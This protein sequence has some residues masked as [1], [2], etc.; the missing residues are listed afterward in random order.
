MA[1]C[2]FSLPISLVMIGRIYTLSDYHHQIGSMNDYSL[3]RVR[4]WNNDMRCMF[5]YIFICV[6]SNMIPQ[7][8]AGHKQYLTLRKT[9][10]QA[11]WRMC[12]LR[13]NTAGQIAT[14]YNDWQRKEFRPWTQSDV[15]CLTHAFIYF[16]LYRLWNFKAISISSVMVLVTA[17]YL[18]TIPGLLIS[19]ENACVVA[20]MQKNCSL[21]P[22]AT[23]KYISYYFYFM[24]VMM[25]W[26]SLLHRTLPVSKVDKLGAIWYG[27]TA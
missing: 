25:M 2:V 7:D 27:D 16:K 11:G 21:L 5:L 26:L 24:M 10:L 22:G 20:I 17:M 18:Q 1:L 23:F 9:D 4:L 13:H 14:Q 3:F 15:A 8:V 19:L 12:M 6:S